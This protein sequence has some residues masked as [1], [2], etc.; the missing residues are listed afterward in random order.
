MKKLI[1]IFLLII[2]NLIFT[3]SKICNF[4]NTILLPMAETSIKTHTISLFPDK[5]SF[6]EEVLLTYDASKGNG[7]LKNYKGDI[8]LHTGL[9]T[10]QSTSDGDWKHIVAGWNENKEEL[11]MKRVGDNIYEIQFQIA[12]L[13]GIPITGGNVAALAFIFR[14]E[15]SF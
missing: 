1:L 2:I 6:N 12:D 13:Y 14:N 4:P 11:R 8:Y 10:N 5:P 3:S 7:E 15:D 9:I